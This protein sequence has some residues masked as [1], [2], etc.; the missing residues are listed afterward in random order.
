MGWSAGRKRDFLP[1]PARVRVAPSTLHSAQERTPAS[2]KC[3]CVVWKLYVPAGRVHS[4]PSALTMICR[5]SPRMYGPSPCSRPAAA[6]LAKANVFRNGPSP[7]FIGPLVNRRQPVAPPPPRVIGA[8]SSIVH[9]IGATPAALSGGLTVSGGY[10]ALA[11]LAGATKPTSYGGTALRLGSSG[12]APA[13]RGSG[14]P[15]TLARRRTS[16]CVAP[17]GITRTRQSP[18]AGLATN[19]SASKTLEPL[20]VVV[21]PSGA[22]SSRSNEFSRAGVS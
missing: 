7:T 20:V 19:A 17:R 1:R 4:L 13:G 12:V 16:A 2:W 6:S 3:A 10:A 14:A 11:G 22:V 9:S 8:I 15:S 21:V 5:L 18:A